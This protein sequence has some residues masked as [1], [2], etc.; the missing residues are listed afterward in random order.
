MDSFTTPHLLAERLAAHHLPDLRRLDSDPEVMAHLGG[1]RD[2]A[3]TRDYL[4]RNLAHWADHGFGL[5]VLR[6]VPS[7]EVVGRACV[8]HVVVDECDEV[9]IGYGFLPAYW[10]RGWA[11]EIAQACVNLAFTRLDCPSVV[12]LTRPMN[13]ASQRVLGKVGLVLEREVQLEGL[14]HLLFRGRPTDR[15]ESKG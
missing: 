8:R 13:R 1:P 3:G 6:A 5:W 10:G 9:E 11:T 14:Q 2:E 7:R 4:E 12:G 15:Q